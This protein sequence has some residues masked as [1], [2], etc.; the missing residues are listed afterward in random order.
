[1]KNHVINDNSAAGLYS[2]TCEINA[3]WMKILQTIPDFSGLGDSIADL[4]RERDAYLRARAILFE[5]DRFPIDFQKS[6]QLKRAI[7]RMRRK[8][9]GFSGQCQ[10]S[11]HH[12]VCRLQHEAAIQKRFFHALA[13]SSEE[14]NIRKASRQVLAHRFKETMNQL[15][16]LIPLA[17]L[18]DVDLEEITIAMNR[19]VHQINR[20]KCQD[21][22]ML[23]L[24][25]FPVY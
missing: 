1:M 19:N 9:E 13:R 15:E 16:L 8:A 3:R 17:S 20:W 25:P 22:K 5:Y 11:I 18:M 24:A 6:G 14:V 21:L 7:N 23:P 10:K 2:F 12:Q 4:I